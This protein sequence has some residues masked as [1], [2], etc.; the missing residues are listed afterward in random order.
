MS[1]PYNFDRLYRSYSHLFDDTPDRDFVSLSEEEKRKKQE[2]EDFR[3]LP[4]YMKYDKEFADALED[5]AAGK[6][7]KGIEVPFEATQKLRDKVTSSIAGVEEQPF[8]KTI[9]GALAPSDLD[10]GE[11][12]AEYG[13]ELPEAIKEVGIKGLEAATDPSQL[14][15]IGALG[16][17]G[18]LLTAPIFGPKMI[19]SGGE[20]IG[21]GISNIESGETEKGLKN[22]TG[23]AFDIGMGGLSIKHPIEAGGE[24]LRKS[25]PPLFEQNVP[26][27]LPSSQ[28]GAI[29]DVSK[30]NTFEDSQF[31][32]YG[33]SWRDLQSPEEST[34]HQGL[35][36][37]SSGSS[38]AD[39]LEKLSEAV[40]DPDIAPRLQELVS[41]GYEINRAIRI[42]KAE[43][44]EIPEEILSP[45]D[46][47]DYMAREAEKEIPMEAEP[48]IKEE[49]PLG[50]I[51]SPLMEEA[52]IEAEPLIGT[53]EPMMAEPLRRGRPAKSIIP[54]EEA[55]QS[56]PSPIKSGRASITE[57]DTLSEAW[58]KLDSSEKLPEIL[59]VFK[60]LRGSGDLGHVLRQGKNLTLDML[61]NDPRELK[62]SL[63]TMAKQGISNEEFQSIQKGYENDPTIK[64]YTD[65]FGLDLPG[66]GKALKEEAFHTSIGEKLPVIS[67]VW[68]NPSN[69][70]YTSYLNAARVYKMNNISDKLKE[71]GYNIANDADAQAFK[72]AAKVVNIVSTR[73]DF[74]KIGPSLN[75]L[76]NW[77]W[78]PRGRLAKAQ[79]L[80]E[81]SKA[82]S[83]LGEQLNP[84]AKAD[85]VRGFERV[86]GVNTALLALAAGTGVATVETDP[87]HT[88]FARFKFGGTV[89]D[90]WFG[91]QPMIRDAARAAMGRKVSSTGNET[92]TNFAAQ[93]GEY[94]ASGA[95]PGVSLA[96]EQATGKTLSGFEK[97]RTESLISS[98]TPM[99]L[100]GIIEQF[101]ENGL[102]TAAA[103][104]PINILGEAVDVRKKKKK[105]YNF[106]SGGGSKSSEFGF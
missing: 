57:A 22:I 48:L 82:R 75:A 53:D 29:G 39:P 14:L 7:I 64:I 40:N 104:A 47:S 56:L 91:L 8:R 9:E 11:V 84:V 97:D 21:T 42:A 102:L 72:D 66:V 19:S 90:P 6:I 101:K 34:Y 38:V 46:V 52:P 18:A 16:P 86:V 80:H 67:K 98:I 50:P 61:F 103:T 44:A 99:S 83:G 96:W 17:A 10:Y 62:E 2:D 85:L 88:D 58:N 24:A 30:L 25:N 60:S 92:P 35:L 87:A 33:K 79:L 1:S 23:G 95:A 81:Y 28:R 37:G 100:E 45:E 68:I 76:S 73:G 105:K 49:A 26:S 106:S 36:K 71:A 65:K 55:L 31:R 43:R 89:I 54:K 70:A 41:E 78:T 5:T 13:T 93:L 69:R 15:P 51:K 77:L 3:N 20:S 27:G 74:K 12:G 63:V 94:A 4:W 32:K 59:S